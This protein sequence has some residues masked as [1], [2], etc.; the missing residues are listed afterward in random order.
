M[1]AESDGEAHGSWRL[2]AW[3]RNGIHGREQ[4]RE[5]LLPLKR[6]D[7]DGKLRAFVLRGPTHKWW[8]EPV[9]MSFKSSLRDKF[10]NNV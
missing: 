1:S 8:A 10:Q 3:E 9:E 4:L 7:G 6:G 2:E 5:L